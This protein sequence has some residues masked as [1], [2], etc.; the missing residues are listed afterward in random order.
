M[1]LTVGWPRAVIFDFFGTLTRAVIRGPWHAA[2]ARQLGCDPD[3]FTRVLD[4]SFRLRSRGWFGSAEATLRWVC[5]QL[6]TDPSP[7]QL[8][9]ARRA[10][11]AAVRA[12]TC[13]RPEAV[14]VLRGIR[15]RGLPIGLISDCGYELP[16]FLPELPVTPLLD[17]CVFSV[18]VGECKPHPA[19]YEQA[20]RRLGVAAED[21]LYVGDGGS[22]ELTGA[23]AHGM[24]AVRLAAVD[25]REHL[26][27]APDEQFTGPAVTSLPQ[28]LALLDTAGVA[29]PSLRPRP[30]A[31][32]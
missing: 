19:L 31:L 26:V 6:G 2:I 12:D 15:A 20:C 23:Q 22:G 11:T 32:R 29:A 8:R 24:S 14:P 18:E 4:E 5:G 21:C 30:A 28:L 16:E 1:S 3:A 7:D 17:A 25:L 10:R 27:F 9:A 13:L